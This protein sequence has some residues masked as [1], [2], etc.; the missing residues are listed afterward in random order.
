MS[1]FTASVWFAVV[2]CSPTEP[3]PETPASTGDSQPHLSTAALSRA[4]AEPD[5]RSPLFDGATSWQ[6]SSTDPRS[7]TPDAEHWFANDDRGNV[8]SVQT[9]NGRRE[10][11]L[12][13]REGSGALVRLW[14]ANP[15]R[16]GI[17]RIVV[18]G[19]EHPVVQAPMAE[20]LSGSSAISPPLAAETGGGF[21]LRAP[22]AYGRH[23]RV[24]MDDNRGKGVYWVAQG[25][26]WRDG[27]APSS[28][29][30]L[31]RLDQTGAALR[32]RMQRAPR[33]VQA[34]PTSVELGSTVS[35]VHL[36]VAE[37]ER[38][39]AVWIIGT[40]DGVQSLE[41]PVTGLCG[42]GPVP[43]DPSGRYAD[44]WRTVTWADGYR[45]SVFLPMPVET[46]GTLALEVRQPEP[47]A[48]GLQVDTLNE[49]RPVRFRLHGVHREQSIATRPRRDVVL[50][51][52][53]GAGRLLSETVT[54]DNPV[55][56]W[57]GGGDEKIWIDGRLERGTG[58]E[59]HFGMA[60]CSDAVFSGPF[61]GQPRNDAHPDDPDSGSSCGRSTGVAT[62]TRA[63][64][65]DLLPWRESLRLT[66]GVRHRADVTIP[67]A[68]T[69][70]F[71]ASVEQRESP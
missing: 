12:V 33:T 34:G 56:D 47:V 55:A 5:P 17:L 27:V 2:G 69:V 7:T 24:T 30:D 45:C 68:S 15:E 44:V 59:D 57:W 54:I 20:L 19:A 21:T 63:R 1:W 66:L 18:D 10:Y 22:I 38:A 14:S 48:A 67:Y 49:Q 58:T 70:L 62:A 4:L 61:G 28:P 64:V 35:A 26:E 42:S 65:L 50:L 43:S 60:W 36:F 52:H 25:I 16:G 41:V 39:D 8:A 40:F 31:A 9:T 23:L 29:D 13:D 37:P 51:D 53:E 71:L 3:P 11:V 32:D 6:T 46:S